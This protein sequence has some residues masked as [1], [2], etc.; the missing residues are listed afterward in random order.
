MSKEW[1]S[2]PQWVHDVLV[3]ALKHAVK[4]RDELHIVLLHLQHKNN[5]QNPFQ[6]PAM[7]ALLPPFHLFHLV[8]QFD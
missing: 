6:T 7:V 5:S 1:G 8:V 2:S 4:P 3:D